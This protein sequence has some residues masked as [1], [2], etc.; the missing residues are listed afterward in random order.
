[1]KK[2]IGMLVTALLLMGLL[3]LAG[4]DRVKEGALSDIDMKK[5]AALLGEKDP[6]SVLW[7]KLGLEGETADELLAAAKSFPLAGEMVVIENSQITAGKELLEGFYENNRQGEAGILLLL[8]YYSLTGRR[9]GVEL[10]EEE[11]SQYPKAFLS[12][13]EYDGK[14]YRYRTRESGS[15]E[16]E[17]GADVCFP[18]LIHDTEE[19]PAYARYGK[20]EHYALVH[21]ESLTWKQLEHSLFSSDFRDHISFRRVASDYYNDSPAPEGSY[22]PEEEE[23]KYWIPLEGYEDRE[24]SFVMTSLEGNEA[25]KIFPAEASGGARSLIAYRQG[26]RI[27]WRKALSF[28]SW[29][30]RPLDGGILISGKQDVAYLT[31][32]GLIW[33]A[34]HAGSADTWR[35]LLGAEGIGEHIIL[36]F[37]YTEQ[38]INR[39][40]L[41][42]LDSEGKI[43]KIHE[44]EL[45]KGIVRAACVVEGGAYYV[46]QD[47]HASATARIVRVDEAHGEAQPASLQMPE[48]PEGQILVVRDL[49]Q[50]PEDPGHI[51]LS[52]YF[53]DTPAKAG[54]YSNREE[55]QDAVEYG[56]HHLDFQESGFA[57]SPELTQMVQERYTA[58]LY[59][60]ELPI[61]DSSPSPFVQGRLLRSWPGALGG[62]LYT[63][64]EGEIAWEIE[65]IGEVTYSIATSSF[66]LMAPCRVIQ[67]FYHPGAEEGAALLGFEPGGYRLTEKIVYFRR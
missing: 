54:L 25:R 24:A 9:T 35:V 32:E 45:G 61:P 27:L 26:E 11:I 41:W 5:M 19:L 7:E 1:M 15:R 6:A 13:L 39:A 65:E 36:A 58:A 8:Q 42:T 67:Y 59:V 2:Q 64:Q 66:T 47:G 10:F 16:M 53:C 48:A 46:L 3:G 50:S 29:H 21:D 40:E 28:D 51:Y 20:G 12:L 23:A 57:S 43:L 17:E 63:N 55:V 60:Y 4:C 38:E 56:F 37:R 30:S 14:E 33:H 52:A 44:A 22:I 31:S 34:Y 18:Y 62:F 49:Y